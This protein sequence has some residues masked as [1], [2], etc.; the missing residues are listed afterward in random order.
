MNSALMKAT[1]ELVDE[2]G[3]YLA[4]VDLFRA[5][6]CEPTWQP[7]WADRAVPLGRSSSDPREQRAVH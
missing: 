4:A 1:E 6:D 5:Q 2:I 7:E 3:R